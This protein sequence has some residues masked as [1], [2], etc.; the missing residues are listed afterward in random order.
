MQYLYPLDT[1]H[2][3]NL[4]ITNPEVDKKLLHQRHQNEVM[5]PQQLPPYAAVPECPQKITPALCNKCTTT[6]KSVT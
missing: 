2:Q 1:S 5:L 6:N 4:P 3:I